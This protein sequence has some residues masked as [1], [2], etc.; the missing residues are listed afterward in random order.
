MPAPR[1]AWDLSPDAAGPLA[2]GLRAVAA[3]FPERFPPANPSAR[4]IHFSTLAPP[5]P[6]DYAITPDADTVT[7]QAARRGDAFH[8]LGRLMA[9]ALAGRGEEPV[10]ATAPH[11]RA[12]V[13][14][15]V[16]RNGVLRPE[17][18]REW[19]ARFALMGVNTLYLYMEDTCLVPDEPFIGYFRGGYTADDLRALDDHAH[20][21]GIEIVP[22]IQTLGHLEQILQ[23]PAYADLADT[24]R[25]LL[26][27]HPA[28][29]PLL[30]RILDAAT[31]P[32][33]SRR[34]HL[35]L[36]EAAGVGSGRHLLR[37]GAE[38]AH[39]ILR[40][41]LDRVLALCRDRNLEP[42]IWSD[43]FFR[44]GSPTRDYYESDAA[45]D[46][47]RDLPAELS[48]VYWDYYH[49]DP[50]HHRRMFERHRAL[51]R[52]LVFAGGAWTWNR[53][54]ANLP[55]T[56]ATLAPGLAAAREAGCEEV[57]VTLWGDDGAECDPGSALAGAQAFATLVHGGSA[58]RDRLAG[59]FRATCDGDFSAWLAAS[60]LDCPASADGELLPRQGNLSKWLLWHDPVLGFLD[61]SLPAYLPD[62]YAR[63]ASALPPDPRL[64]FP[65]QLARVLTLKADL[66]LRL[67]SAA[68]D[69]RPP[70]LRV[71]RDE[72]L[73][74]LREAVAE[75]HD[76]HR[77]RWRAFY[78]PFGWE[79]LDRRHGGLRARI[80]TLAALL[81]ELIADPSRDAEWLT[82][83][84]QTVYPGLEA[85][86]CGLTWARASTPSW[87]K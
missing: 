76:L 82:T 7:I 37:H 26:A 47:V 44:L 84:P 40:R 65:R 61:A 20:A 9:D 35:G 73:P 79:V 60:A 30:G 55:T 34:V 68:R 29:L 51:G 22:C 80:D 15:D 6:A 58:P 32:F 11:R 21:L 28:T 13:L 74:A 10:A 75:L 53:L 85:W 24:P 5:A 4:R 64:D 17:V 38:P 46:A 2:E 83:R 43:M 18:L 14:L 41:H 49:T 57:L 52:R 54:W 25:I 71:L 16:S 86:E 36:D 39:A 78:R 62:H 77:R 56:L 23:W 42:M 1:V 3:L 69:R 70:V 45:P 12:G 66:H 72:A 33:R 31:A 50:A 27:D 81:D 19:L 67:R 87:I 48:V 63:L 8:A 59:D